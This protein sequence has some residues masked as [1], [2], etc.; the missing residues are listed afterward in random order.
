M[1]FCTLF[2]S[3]YLDKGLVLYKSICKHVPTF[4]L[5]I[6]AMDELAERILDDIKLDGIIIISLPLFVEK[7]FLKKESTERTKA[8]FC[9]TCTPF[10]IDYVIN[11]FKESI[12]TYIDADMYFYKDPQVLI[13]EMGQKSVQ[14]VE[15]RFTNS[16]FDKHA[17]K[18]S[19]QYCVEFNTF[20]NDTQAMNLLKWWENK[21]RE[22][23]S[24]KGV[25]GVMGDQFYLN[26]WGK[27]DYVSVLK[28][29]GGGVA[30]W[31]V[32]QYQLIHSSGDNIVFRKK[33]NKNKFDLIFYH[34]H[35]LSYLN[36]KMVDISVY[37]RKLC[38]DS[39]LV[40]SIYIPYLKKID[41]EKN[42]LRDKYNFYP[43]LIKH[44]GFTSES[45]ERKSFI[46]RIKNSIHK[47]GF[48]YTISAFLL[49]I[50]NSI[51]NL[52]NK[53]KNYISIERSSENDKNN[54]V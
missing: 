12:C 3:N 43:L 53:H 29:L 42:H 4:K 31:N 2:D 49:R 44:P 48:F 54:I 35:N 30:P 25:D 46:E 19:G 9:W 36:E 20:R 27:Y 5:Y 50:R 14:I 38:V 7:M 11:N 37:H 52:F 51:V 18:S 15:H 40:N 22:S 47:N 10:L 23:C 33:Y 24:Q 17:K 34:F 21:C 8:E 32:G 6:L 39:K 45:I 13:D 28:N 16:L 1:I 26:G 41:G